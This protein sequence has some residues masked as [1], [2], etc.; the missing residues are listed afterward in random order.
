MGVEQSRFTLGLEKDITHSAKGAPS[1]KL[2]IP[3]C[4][5]WW[6][7]CTMTPVGHFEP[8][9]AEPTT[10]DRMR[11]EVLSRA[12]DA[13]CAGIN[14]DGRWYLWSSLKQTGREAD[15]CITS[16]NQKLGK[17]WTGQGQCK[18]KGNGSKSSHSNQATPPQRSVQVSVENES[19][20]WCR[21]GPRTSWK[22]LC[23]EHQ[24]RKTFAA[25]SVEERMGKLQQLQEQHGLLTAQS[26]VESI[27]G[28]RSNRGGSG[29]NCSS[30][31]S[32][33]SGMNTSPE[34][35]CRS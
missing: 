6:A 23:V 31:Y 20:C 33:K 32:A 9:A 26:R 14:P 27:S 25:T 10:Y 29:S 17:D 1:N 11:A 13:T 8:H 34:E 7:I 19:S 2:S 24:R 4:I 18:G 28:R 3:W 16:P 15:C 30:R 21:H 5:S 22:S 35:S 12:Q